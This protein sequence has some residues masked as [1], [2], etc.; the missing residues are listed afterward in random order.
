MPASRAHLAACVEAAVSCPSM[1]RTRAPAIQAADRSSGRS[2]IRGSRFQ[3]TVRS[4]DFSSIKIKADWLMQPG[5]MIQRTLTPSRSISSCWNFPASSSPILP[6]YPVR[7]PQRRQAVIALAVCPP[8][9]RSAERISTFESRTGKWGRRMTVSVALIPT[10]TT[11]A[12][13]WLKWCTRRLSS[14]L[15]TSARKLSGRIERAERGKRLQEIHQARISEPNAGI[16]S[17]TKTSTTMRRF[18]YLRGVSA[19]DRKFCFA[20]L[21]RRADT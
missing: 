15:R 7:S 1:R 6:I 18:Y 2:A 21:R 5:A 19:C 11:S 20:L 13:D 17:S 4:P 16:L 8:A 14:C 10:P 3:R 9:R 12:G